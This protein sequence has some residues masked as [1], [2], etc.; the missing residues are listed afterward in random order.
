MNDVESSDLDDDDPVYFFV[1]NRLAIQIAI[2]RSSPLWAREAVTVIRRNLEVIALTRRV[3]F[4]WVPGHAG[5]EG[6]EI[7]D[8]LAK[9]GAAGTS[10][11]YDSVGSVPKPAPPPTLF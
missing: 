6:N 8:E 10:A 7:A 1:D 2:G 3:F 11:V 9:L 4:L 5:V